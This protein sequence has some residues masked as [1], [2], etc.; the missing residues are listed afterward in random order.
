M[1]RP[2]R[3]KPSGARA[4]IHV[5]VSQSRSSSSRSRPR[6]TRPPPR[7]CA[8]A[9]SCSRTSSRAR[10]T[11]TRASAASCPRSRAASTPRRS[12]ASST[13]RCERA[14]SARLAT[15]RFADLDAIAVT[16][17]PGLVGALVV[18]LAYAKGLA[19]ATGLPLVGV[20]HLEGHIFANV[21]A[22]PEV[23]PPLVA[24]VVSGGHTSLVHMPEW[25]VYRTLGET[26]DDAA[27][28]AF[29][30]VAKVL[31]P[32]LPGRAGALE[33]RREGR[34]GGDRLPARDDALAATTASRCPG[35][36]PRSSTTSATSAR[37]AERSTCPTL[38]R[39]SSR[40]SSTCRSPRRSG[41]SRRPARTAFCLA[42]G[43]A[44]NP[45]L[46]DGADAPRS[47][48]SACT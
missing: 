18:G 47:S 45:A 32:R 42:G 3:A 26:L 7:S 31:G 44:A 4:A 36:R 39:R 10:S 48:R 5:E 37:P 46:R 17:G 35:S 30:K 2:R 20:N 40:P 28:E 33:A 6:A 1:G 43:V 19:I 23:A 14:A 15:A 12:S 16:Y 41:R 8:A 29:D 11:S 25:G 22:D 27:G 21:L 24:L 38:P 13:R 34:P 9:A